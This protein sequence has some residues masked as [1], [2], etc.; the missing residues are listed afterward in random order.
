MPSSIKLNYSASEVSSVLNA[1]SIQTRRRVWD[2][3]ETVGISLPHR[4]CAFRQALGNGKA[5]AMPCPALFFVICRER[6]TVVKRESE[7]PK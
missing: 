7:R 2:E 6:G 1:E 3:F 4:I 5:S